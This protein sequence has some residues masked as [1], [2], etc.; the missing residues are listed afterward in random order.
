MLK[1][2]IGKYGD[3]KELTCC[4]V[5]YSAPSAF[6]QLPAKTLR[7]TAEDGET[8]LWPLFASSH[9]INLHCMNQFTSSAFFVIPPALPYL[10]IFLRLNF[11]PIAPR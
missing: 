7:T 8:V 10:V 11:F 2:S 4:G 1:S 6:T 9:T 3:P 5:E